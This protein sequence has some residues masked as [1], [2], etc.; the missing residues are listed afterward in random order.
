MTLWI[1]QPSMLRSA[2]LKMSGGTLRLTSTGLS[3][4]LQCTTFK[5][6]ISTS[7]TAPAS[8]ASSTVTSHPSSPSTEF[9]YGAYM[10]VGGPNAKPVHRIRIPK[11]ESLEAERAFRKLHHAAALRWLGFQGYNNEGAGG[12]VTVRDPVMPDHFWIN[13]HGKSFSHMRPEDL[14]LV[15]KDGEVKEGGNM[16]SINPAG[17]IIHAA[18]HEARPDVIAAV[19]CHSVPSKAFSAIGC[20]LEPINQDACRFYNDHGVYSG[21]G[22]IVFKEDE[23]RHIAQALG[24]TKGVIL[25]NHG[26]LT[27][28]KTVDGAAFL[29]GAMDRCIQAQLLADAAC[30]GRGSTT[31]KVGHEEAEYT[32]NTYNDEMVYIMFQSAF[33]D[34]VK[35]SNGELAMHV[36]GETP[37][38]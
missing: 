31:I 27:V 12:H 25:Q 22:G 29:F 26:H 32:R 21:F 36:Q 4:L 11:F 17:Y 3:P 34:V 19:H 13:P 5:H 15:S 2:S 30:A 9:T 14:V 7:K 35:A 10:K 20:K 33:E 38:A 23:G 8:V 24:G 37:R 16:H 1:P 6:S 18:V 28:A